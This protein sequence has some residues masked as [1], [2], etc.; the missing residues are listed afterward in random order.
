MAK[1]DVKIVDAGGVGVTPSRVFRTEA[2][3]T[4]ILV[5]EPVKIGGTGNNYVIPLATGDPEIGTDRMVGI[6]ASNSSHTASADGTI[7]VYIP[8]PGVTLM[9]C[10]AT[11]AANIDTDAKLLALLNDSVTFDLASSTY[12]VDENEG[13]D[14]D[15]HGLLLVDGDVDNGTLQFVLKD[16]ASING[17]ITV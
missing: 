2:A 5:G 9:E 14:I 10:A 12:T 16:G 1:A 17:E 8:I 4:D 13:D 11:T 7:E 3:A 15:V 6:A